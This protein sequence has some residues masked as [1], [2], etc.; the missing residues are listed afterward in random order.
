MHMY[1]GMYLGHSGTLK[2]SDIAVLTNTLFI[3]TC[4]CIC[5][6]TYLCIYRCKDI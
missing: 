2:H 5:I 6:C 4:V 3:C 1:V